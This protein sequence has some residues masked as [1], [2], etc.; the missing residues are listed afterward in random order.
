MFRFLSWQAGSKKQFPSGPSKHSTCT[1]KNSL[2]DW[3]CY[4]TRSGQCSYN[5]ILHFFKITGSFITMKTWISSGLYILH[6]LPFFQKWDITVC[7][8][9]LQKKDFWVNVPIS[10]LGKLSEHQNVIELR[11]KFSKTLIWEIWMTLYLGRFL[12]RSYFGGG[13]LNIFC[14][15]SLNLQTVWNKQSEHFQR[16]YPY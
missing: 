10:N 8:L 16:K 7:Q 4:R 2:L 13:F 6:R 11:F 15:V 14:L 12:S 3:C 1:I 5:N 9:P